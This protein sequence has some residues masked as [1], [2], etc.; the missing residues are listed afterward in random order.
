V[1]DFL[2]RGHEAVGLEG[3]DYSLKNQR[4]EWRLLGKNRLFTSDIARH[5]QVRHPDGQPFAAHIV[6]AWEFLEHI[7]EGDLPQVFENVRRHLE[8]D[9]YFLGTIALNDDVVEG[10][11][12]HPTVKPQKWWREKFSESGFFWTEEHSFEF[13][14]FCR[15]SGNGY[16]DGNYLLNPEIGFHFVAR[17][18]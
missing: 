1:W 6:T 16:Y 15:G 10:V 3:S 12:Y 4:A 13:N 8:P 18:S 17:K 9:G 11:S 7:K 5:F 2:L 14:D